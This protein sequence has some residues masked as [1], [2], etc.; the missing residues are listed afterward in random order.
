M[1][2]K[3]GFNPAA[4][5]FRNICLASYIFYMRILFLYVTQDTI[6]LFKIFSKPFSSIT[7]LTEVKHL[8]HIKC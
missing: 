5:I 7:F 8:N 2:F 6:K 3:L 4:K 1:E